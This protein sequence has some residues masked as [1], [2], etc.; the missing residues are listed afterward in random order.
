M[1]YYRCA[2]TCEKWCLWQ[3]LGAR[4]G[5]ANKVEKKGDEDN[6]DT[7]EFKANWRG[8]ALFDLNFLSISIRIYIYRYNLQHYIW[9]IHPIYHQ[10]PW[11]H[12]GTYMWV[13]INRKPLS[14][15]L[16]AYMCLFKTGG[17]SKANR[18]LA[19]GPSNPVSNLNIPHLWFGRD[20]K[21]A[22]F[23]GN[24]TSSKCMVGTWGILP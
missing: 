12:S 20:H 1:Q 18:V 23:Q 2:L 15:H 13:K 3:M 24:Q 9:S 8:S 21:I 14:R 5:L 17:L 11:Y 6:T 22:L 16:C 19:E 4:F 10:H 7:S